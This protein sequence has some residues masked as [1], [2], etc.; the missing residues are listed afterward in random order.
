MGGGFLSLLRGNRGEGG[1]GFSASSVKK[2]K[3]KCP[4]MTGGSAGVL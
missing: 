3:K 2:K 4:L 1:A